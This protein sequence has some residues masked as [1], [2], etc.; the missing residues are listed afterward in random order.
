MHV[1]MRVLN[2]F[3]CLPVFLYVYLYFISLYFSLKMSSPFSLSFLKK[4]YLFGYIGS[5]LPMACVILVPLLRTEPTSP[6]LEGVFSAAGP[7]GK[8]LFLSFCK[9]TSPLF[10]CLCI[11][12]VS[13]AFRLSVFSLFLWVSVLVFFLS[14]PL[15][16][17]CLHFCLFSCIVPSVFPP[18]SSFFLLL[19]VCPLPYFFLFSLGLLPD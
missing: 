2:T 8:S 19:C 14:S 6:G 17:L 7:P 5:Q 1:C 18:V 10:T 4:I 12:N 16:F 15:L 11:F 3:F 13:A 9:L